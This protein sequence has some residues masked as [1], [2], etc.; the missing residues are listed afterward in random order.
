MN[1]RA[2]TQLDREA[3]Y[4][5]HWAAFAEDERELVSKLAVDLLLG[6]TSPKTIS[7]VADLEGVVVGHVAFSPVSIEGDESFRGFILGPLGVMP[8]YQNCGIGTKLIERGIQLVSSLRADVLFVYGDP[9][10]YGKFDFSTDAAECY[11]PPSQLQYPFGWQ[12][13]ALNDNE[14]RTIPANLVVVTALNNPELW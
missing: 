5:V 14:V 13:I 8:D 12:A 7:L 10:Y 6:E 3:I 1:V 9:K 2:A 4:S 11:V